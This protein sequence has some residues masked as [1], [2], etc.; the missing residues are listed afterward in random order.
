MATRRNSGASRQQEK[1]CFGKQGVWLE[2]GHY[3]SLIRDYVALYPSTA[4]VT[5]YELRFFYFVYEACNKQG[6]IF[7]LVIFYYTLRNMS[8]SS[9]LFGS[10]HSD[11]QLLHC[12]TAM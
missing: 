8:D 7:V 3:R 10:I 12:P 2:V 4:F 5:S 9:L 1:L 6:I 11:S